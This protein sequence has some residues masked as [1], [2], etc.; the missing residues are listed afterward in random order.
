[1]NIKA[2]ALKLA[3][4]GTL[5]AA[6]AVASPAQA[7][8]QVS[9]G[10]RVGGPVYHPY[11]P[12]RPYYAPPAYGYGYYGHPYYGRGF[13]HHPYYGRPYGYGYHRW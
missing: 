11:A 4:L 3:T 5:A 6:F 13:Y 7:N 1:M 12:V 10:V 2:T 9:F 8:A